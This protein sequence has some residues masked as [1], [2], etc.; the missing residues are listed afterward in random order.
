MQERRAH[1]GGAGARTYARNSP[2]RVNRHGL[3]V[4]IDVSLMHVADDTGDVPHRPNVPTTDVP[5]EYSV[6]PELRQRIVV[7]SHGWDFALGYSSQK[8]WPWG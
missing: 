5:R 8:N 3:N 1:S 6:A 4:G 2:T 7:Q